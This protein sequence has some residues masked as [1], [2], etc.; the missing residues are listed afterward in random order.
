M[1]PSLQPV[2]PRLK[3]TVLPSPSHCTCDFWESRMDQVEDFSPKSLRNQFPI[4]SKL[5]PPKGVRRCITNLGSFHEL[6][7]YSFSV[8]GSFHSFWWVS[9]KGSMHKHV[10]RNML[11]VS[12]SFLRNLFRSSGSR[13]DQCKRVSG[14]LNLCDEVGCHFLRVMSLRRPPSVNSCSYTLPTFLLG[15]WSCSN[16]WLFMEVRIIRVS[17]G[18]ELFAWHTRYKNVSQS[19]VCLVSL[20][21]FWST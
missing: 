21:C 1:L 17:K 20:Y 11:L 4:L 6:L 3:P 16:D 18:Y 13:I 12:V 14:C 9:Q 15:C 19:V 2:S 10:F 5:C 7:G 8:L